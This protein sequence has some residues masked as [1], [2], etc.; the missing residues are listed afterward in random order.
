MGLLDKVTRLKGPNLPRSGC[1]TPDIN[2]TGGTIGEENR[3]TA[4]A[5]LAVFRVADGHAGDVGRPILLIQVS[6]GLNPE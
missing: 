1:S 2:T 3:R 4:R 6:L 5:G